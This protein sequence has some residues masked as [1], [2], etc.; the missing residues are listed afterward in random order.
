VFGNLGWDDL[1][2]VGVL[3]AFGLVVWRIAI[4]AMTKKLID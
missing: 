2:R 1:F 4:R 3:V